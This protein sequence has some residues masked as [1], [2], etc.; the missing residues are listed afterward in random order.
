MGSEVYSGFYWEKRPLMHSSAT[1]ITFDKDPFGQGAE[2][3]VYQLREIDAYGRFVGP[4]L[5]A[6]EGRF[7]GD[8][9]Q[10]GNFH[11]SFC[12]TQMI[13]ANMAMRF[14]Q[15]LEMSQQVGEK[16]P[17]IKF[18]DC[19]VYC[20]FVKNQDFYYLVEKQLDNNQ[21]KKW[22]DNRGGVRGQHR[23][24]GF[25]QE[26]EDEEVARNEE[27]TALKN[28][29]LKTIVSETIIE[30]NSED[31][32]SDED[33]SHPMTQTTNVG[34]SKNKLVI[35]NE[36][37]PQAFSHFTYT[38]SKQDKI[39]CDLQG[40]L[41]TSKKPPVFEFTDSVM[42]YKSK[43]GRKNVFGRTDLGQTGINDFFKTH[44]C[45]N[46]CKALDYR[47]IICKVNLVRNGP[48]ST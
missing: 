28:L 46:V 18:L 10:R 11:R 4:E 1:G 24:F 5:V 9:Y 20:F 33:T 37:V 44:K 41:D 15:R 3:L 13:A 47:Q 32:L 29:N 34:C 27:A 26:K 31:E 36:D 12:K 2:R 43:S 14:N 7:E 35:M 22:N 48:L 42:H 25:H 8:Y 23:K 38:W 19:Y 16:V 21:Y 45:N 17:R 39:V 30:E 6:K 40:V